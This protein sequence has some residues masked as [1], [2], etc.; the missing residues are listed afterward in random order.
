M[1]RNERASYFLDHMHKIK[2]GLTTG[3]TANL[4]TLFAVMKNCDHDD[5]KDLAEKMERECKCKLYTSSYSIA[6]Y[7]LYMHMY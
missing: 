2:P 4:F 3:D 1:Q 6:S 7:I 5:V